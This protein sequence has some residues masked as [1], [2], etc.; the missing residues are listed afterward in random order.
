MTEFTDRINQGT[1]CY[2]V[3]AINNHLE[4]AFR[5]IFDGQLNQKE[6]AFVCVMSGEKFSLDER[7]RC[8]ELKNYEVS[9]VGKEL[10]NL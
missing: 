8:D 7:L 6:D 10:V 9:P 4:D 2:D 5:D 1:Q 3:D